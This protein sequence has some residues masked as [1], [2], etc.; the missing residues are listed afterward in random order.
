MAEAQNSGSGFEPTK[1]EASNLRRF[2]VPAV[3]LLVV[4]AVAT[5]SGAVEKVWRVLTGNRMPVEAPVAVPVSKA[6]LSEHEREWLAQQEPQRQMEE[7]V[8]AAVNHEEGSTQMIA[9]RLPSWHGR[10]RNTKSWSDLMM[11]ALYSNDLRVRAAA[12]EINLEVFHLSKSPAT[13]SQLIDQAEND[14]KA[15]PW[16]AWMLGMLANRGVST[17][18]VVA[19]LEDWAHA[20][21]EQTRTWAVEALANVGTDSTVNDFVSILKSD[22]SA[23]VRERA[24]CSLAKSGM[25]TR[26]QRMHAVPG[27]IDLADDTTLNEQTRIWVYQALR[28]ITEQNLPN[29]SGAWRDWYLSHG[30]ELIQKFAGADANQVLGNS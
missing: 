30:Q 28:E 27:L 26:V 2:L 13:V 5:K 29:E 16:A 7:L 6:A 8:R 1:P 3:L 25:L 19:Q 18:R 24:G 4:M 14:D 15:R 10:L 17:E 20:P 9:E 21:D 22:E 23:A 12:I 11:T